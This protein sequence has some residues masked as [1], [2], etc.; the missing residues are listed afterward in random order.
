MGI[1]T[2]IFLIAAGAILK[3]AVNADIQG[4]EIQTVGTILLVLGIVGLVISIL[5]ATLWSDRYRRDRE[6][7]EEVPV[8]ERYR[9][10]Y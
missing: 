1:G 6:V 5:F 8:R 10:R 4:V 9:D 3:Y 7:V 2:S